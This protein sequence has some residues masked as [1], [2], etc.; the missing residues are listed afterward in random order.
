MF[1]FIGLC[2]YILD[3]SSLSLLAHRKSYPHGLHFILFPLEL[4]NCIHYL[5]V[6]QY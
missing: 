1:M 3:S 5:F 4:F 6:L 2:M